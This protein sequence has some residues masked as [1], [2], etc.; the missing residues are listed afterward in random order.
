MT[1]LVHKIICTE[2]VYEFS[3]T[4]VQD[5][6]GTL[7]HTILVHD[8]FSTVCVTCLLVAVICTV[9]IDTK[10]GR[11]S[12]IPVVNYKV[13]NVLKTAGLVYCTWP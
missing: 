4:S 9:P 5:N 3:T 1:T 13:H 8:H 7:V 12:M 2:M 11:N 10:T 6:F